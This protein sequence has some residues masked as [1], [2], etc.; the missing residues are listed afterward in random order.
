METQTEQGEAVRDVIR[1]ELMSI[2]EEHGLWVIEDCSQAHGCRY[3][4]QMGGSI[5]HLAAFSLMSG[6]HSTAGGQGGMV[7]CKDEEHYW[8][9]KRFADRSDKAAPL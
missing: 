1:E 8:N 9:A 6:K 2:A 7:V 4:G 5:G 3:G